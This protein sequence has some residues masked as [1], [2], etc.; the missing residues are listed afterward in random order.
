MG[1]GLPAVG[2]S[3]SVRG[4]GASTWCVPV[5]WSACP[6]SVSKNSAVNIKS[7]RREDTRMSTTCIGGLLQPAD[8]EP[9]GNELLVLRAPPSLRST[10]DE[11]SAFPVHFLDNGG[12]QD[13]ATLALQQ[14]KAPVL[15]AYTVDVGNVATACEVIGVVEGTSHLSADWH[16]APP[17]WAL[18]NAAGDLL[19]SVCV[20]TADGGAHPLIA[21]G[22]TRL[23]ARGECLLTTSAHGVKELTFELLVGTRPAASACRRLCAL[24]LP[25]STD[26]PR[27]LPQIR[28]AVAA[29]AGALHIAIRDVQTGRSIC[30]VLRAADLDQDDDASSAS[31]SGV[32][33]QALP[34]PWRFET[35]YTEQPHP[36]FCCA[37]GVFLSVPGAHLPAASGASPERR[38]GADGEVAPES[39]AERVWPG[40]YLLASYLQQPSVA[41]TLSGARVIELGAGLG[42]PGLAAWVR[43]AA[44]VTLTDLEENL[45]R[46]RQA[47]TANLA[48]GPVE[49]H[50][51]DWNAPLPCSLEAH[52]DLILA[53]DCVYWT[54]LFKPLLQTLRSLCAA[55][56]RHASAQET[57]R[58]RPQVLIT[59]TSRLDRAET[60]AAMAAEAGW[61]AEELLVPDTPPSFLHTKLL[62]LKDV[63]S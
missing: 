55:A 54:G 27:G 44:Q 4:G 34:T 9:Q 18:T 39:T 12:D 11:A 15:A 58:P 3:L 42:I 5:P 23:P 53:A 40:A 57:P 24:T 30:R 1:Q 45:P 38:L 61:V 41:S 52:W 10:A 51:L 59:V 26:S 32:G 2:A 8:V 43:G 49:V 56:Q 48:D 14:P 47:V 63:S 60:F 13:V 62:R 25:V 6:L 33:G 46:L 50:A 28:L 22:G 35:P 37:G 21:R 7:R 36:G 20:R 29:S 19:L 31:H 16:G 17:P